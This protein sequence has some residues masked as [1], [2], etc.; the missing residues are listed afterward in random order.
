MQLRKRPQ[1]RRICNHPADKWLRRIIRECTCMAPNDMGDRRDYGMRTTPGCLGMSPCTIIDK[2]VLRAARK[3]SSHRAFSVAA[4][5]SHK[6][7]H[8]PRALFAISGIA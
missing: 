6:V 8:N 3:S 1:S 2:F 7:P 5:G 4:L